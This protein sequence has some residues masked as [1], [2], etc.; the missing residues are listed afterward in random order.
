MLPRAR[1]Q[2]GTHQALHAP[3]VRGA[4]GQGLFIPAL[5]FVTVPS[6]FGHLAS[7]VQHVV[8]HRE[9]VSGLLGAGGGLRG[10]PDAD[11]DLSCRGADTPELLA[12]ALPC[13]PLPIPPFKHAGLGTGQSTSDGGSCGGLK[14]VPYRARPEWT[15]PG[16]PQ[17]ELP[18][19]GKGG[20]RLRQ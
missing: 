10:L 6:E 3:H 8:G 11:V 7:H 16:H 5:R 2:G 1:R 14:V 20:H 9:E 19:Q 15:G 18:E 17:Q 4:D 12:P 13:K